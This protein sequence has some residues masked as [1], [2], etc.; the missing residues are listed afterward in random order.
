[1]PAF[2]R[3]KASAADRPANLHQKRCRRSQ[4]LLERGRITEITHDPHH[5]KRQHPHE[6]GS[7]QHLLLFGLHGIGEHVHDLELHDILTPVFPEGADLLQG[8]GGTRAVAV[9]EQS[10]AN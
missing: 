9:N 2:M 5:R 10:N 4:Q 8:S 3:K 7:R 1:M 6:R